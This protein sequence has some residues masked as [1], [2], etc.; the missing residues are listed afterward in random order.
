MQ[1]CKK[2][3]VNFS[4]K[5]SSFASTFSIDQPRTILHDYWSAQNYPPCPFGPPRTILHAHLVRPD[6]SSMPIGPPRK[7]LHAYWST[8]KDASDK[9]RLFPAFLLGGP[10]R[11]AGGRRPPFGGRFLT[12]WP[13]VVWPPQPARA[14]PGLGGRFLTAVGRLFPLWFAKK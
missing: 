4:Q 1:A 13:P 9:F 12:V 6:L 10:E 5:Y 14:P 7:V 11:G 8:Q 3:I 2:I